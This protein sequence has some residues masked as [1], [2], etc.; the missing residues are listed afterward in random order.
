M[1]RPFRGIITPW[2]QHLYSL[3]E[4]DMIRLQSE[5]Q[6]E[7]SANVLAFF[8][9]LILLTGVKVNCYHFTSLFFWVSIPEIS[10]RDENWK[11]TMSINCWDQPSSSG[12][13]L[14][15][16][17]SS[18]MGP[19]LVLSSR[20]IFIILIAV[21][22]NFV[23]VSRESKNGGLCAFC[24]I[25]FLLILSFYSLQYRHILTHYFL[26]S[27]FHTFLC[28]DSYFNNFPAALRW[29]SQELLSE[30]HFHIPQFCRKKLLLM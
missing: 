6:T 27:I 5:G 16:I 26:L 30:L 11:L 28:F 24:L 7:Y 10:N 14:I 8:F 4:C 12:Y 2:N 25:F 21:V 9:F 19:L 17:M 3:E 23:K 22:C 13:L 18:L 20:S 29:L 15:L 1:S